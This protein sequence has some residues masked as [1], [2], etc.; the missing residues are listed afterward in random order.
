MAGNPLI[1]IPLA[2]YWA[3][4]AILKYPSL[5]PDDVRQ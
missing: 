3:T 2:E 4:R 1:H 5:C